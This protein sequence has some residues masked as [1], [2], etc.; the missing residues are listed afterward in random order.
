MV[1]TVFLM[2]AALVILPPP[3]LAAFDNK[4][5]EFILGFMENRQ[6]KTYPL[7]DVQLFITTFSNTPAMVSVS[8]PLFN[9]SFRKDITVTKGEVQTVKVP[10][11]IRGKGIEKSNKGIRIQATEEVSVYGVNLEPH[12][13]DA[14]V[15]LPVD[16]LGKEYYALTYE[17][18]AELMVIATEDGTDVSI[19]WPKLAG[20]LPYN[21]VDYTAGDTLKLTLDKYETF[22]SLNLDINADFTGAHIVSSKPVAVVSGNVKVTIPKRDLSADHLTEMMMPV[23]TWGKTFLSTS[24]PD[25]S[26]GDLYRFVA[27]EDATTITLSGFSTK[28]FI[29]KAGDFVTLDIPSTTYTKITSD[30]PIMVAM[31]A[32][33]FKND[34]QFFGDPSMSLIIPEPQYANEYTWATVKTPEGQ[35]FNNKISVIVE[36][37]KMAGLR[38]DGHPITWYREKG[39]V[40]ST[41]MNLWV[42]VTPGSHNIFHL[43]PTVT[44]MAHASGTAKQNS[45]AYQ[46][47]MNLARINVRCTPT[48][49]VPGDTIDNDCD[50][51]VDEEILN[52][53][54]DDGDGLID[55][56]LAETPNVDGNWG[57]WGTYGPCS[58]TCGTGSKSR[59]RQ[60][61]NPAPMGGGENCTGSASDTA[62]CTMAAC[63]VDGNWGSWGPYMECSVTCGDG[64]KSRT[65]Q[66]DNPAP[67]NGGSPCSGSSTDNTECTAGSP[68]PVDGNWGS[69]GPYGVCSVTCGEGTKSRTRECDNPA[70]QHGGNTCYGPGTDSVQCNTAACPIDGNWGSWGPY[71]PCSVTCGEGSKSRTRQCDSPAP[72]NGGNICSGSDLN[73]V[74]CNI[75]AC[76]IDGNW[77]SWGTY[78]PCS[79]TCGTGSKSRTRQCDNPAPMGGGENCTGS[80]SDTSDCIMADCEV[81]PENG[82]DAT[83]VIASIDG[84]WGSWGTYGPCSVT[85]GT[86]SKSRTR[87]CDNPAPVGSGENCTGSAS[88]T[89]DCT[90]AACEVYPENGVDATAVI[91]SIDGNWGSWGTYGPCSVTCGTGSKSRTRQ[92]DNPAPV[93]SGENCTGSA[94]DT[95]DCT[96]AA[97]GVDGNWGSWGPYM[98][99]SV[100]CG[101]GIKSRTRQCD[102]PAPTNG[103]SPCSGSST[104]NTECT[105]GSPCPVDGNWGSWVSGLC[106][107]TCGRGMQTRT[108]QCD[109]PAPQHGGNDCSGSPSSRSWCFRYCIID[110]NWGSWGPYEP[111]SVTCGTGIKTRYRWCNNPAPGIG[112]S[113]CAGSSTERSECTV[114]SCPVD[115]NWGSWGPYGLCSVT[116]GEGTKSRTRECDNP[117]PQHGGNTCY[118]PG[119]DSVQCNTAACP[120]DGNW[121]SWGPYKPCSVTCGEGSKSRTRQCDNPAPQHGGNTCYGPGTDSVQ[122]NTAACP[123]DGNWGSWGPYGPC[124]V[125]CGEGSKSR[126]RQC[127]NPAP[128]NGGNSCSGP[129]ANN[130]QCNVAA[131]PIDGNWGSWGPYEPCSVTCGEGSKSR[132]RQ[133]DNPA[134]QHGGNTCY[135]PG[136]DS[137]QC[138]T[139]ACPI[140]GNWGSWGPYGPCSVTCGEGSK[141]RTRQCD[142]PAPQNGGNTCSG[143]GA[144]IAQC[145]VAAC[146]IDGNWGSWGPYGPCSVTCG[147]GTKSRTRQCDNP[148]PQ[149]GGSMCF[150]S[151]AH[152]TPCTM[153]M[154]SSCS[155]DVRAD[156]I[157]VLD[158]SGSVGYTNFE[159]LKSFIRDLVSA[160]EIAPDKIRVGVQ[161]YSTSTNA[162]IHLNQ[163]Y[164]KTT[165]ERE[166]MNIRFTGGSTN[167]GGAL[168]FTRTTMFT[169]VHGDRS[170]VPNICVVFTDGRSNSYTYTARE[171]KKAHDAGIA[172]LAIGVGL[173]TPLNELS[174]M[175]S[176]PDADV[177]FVPEFSDLKGIERAFHDK[178]CTLEQ[179][180]GTGGWGQWGA[181]ST[182]TKTCGAGHRLRERECHT[183]LYTPTGS[184]CSGHALETRTC[185]NVSCVGLQCPDSY[186]RCGSGSIHCVH[187]NQLCDGDKDCEDGSDE[188]R[189]HADCQPVFCGNSAEIFLPVS[190]TTFFSLL[191]TAAL[192]AWVTCCDITI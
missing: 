157:F 123:I 59:T 100:T 54:D 1:P 159:T 4:G 66:C 109:N 16:V 86:G 45:Y 155:G 64:I 94:S 129:G 80:A 189:Y 128:Q 179:I 35:D 30:K 145:N 31:F 26:I 9:P 161:K 97:C 34:G 77:G 130:A 50:G 119:T 23:D 101:D 46:A 122:C 102:N 111:C 171:A 79:V 137:V 186:F 89:A 187:R 71:E 181:W 121:G 47:G 118:G 135:G 70:P 10:H 43:D 21:G 41:K 27:S 172:V 115:G 177:F 149:H 174:M 167:T 73:S 169:T 93:G 131:C 165:L 25:R 142:N 176:N 7:T 151:A 156:I 138:N 91:A 192:P 37:S 53:I 95:A 40:G 168:E 180:A 2:M 5:K 175:A 39:I 158:A 144:N 178:A 160:F 28:Q 48:K 11:S 146:P 29:D 13:T 92:C 127:D 141:S 87:Q 22:H 82:V 133:C 68:C 12:S 63:E 140:D 96:M 57:S 15:A 113:P 190:L 49:T 36:K 162:E 65:R 19:T 107:V 8:I 58:V 84:N 51:T 170:G 67:T 20:T 139:A 78:G 69:W 166:I 117:A 132:T 148:A 56:D 44:F 99:C 75:A 164:D 32:K 104:D 110:G 61:D 38:M 124:S 76:P 114:G 42:R 147:E 126:T 52:N 17:N 125:T 85:C 18:D 55:E 106:S 182:C 191:M 183:P 81:Y 184:Q 153:P 136:T 33:T 62:D 90:M 143:P 74:Q 98:E 24:T 14:Y 103:G 88:D 150:G 83:A 134:P 120:I 116:C 152:D 173:E 3:S 108:R 112:G 188:D 105:A 154:C 60:C 185:S 163:Y 6:F 72:Q